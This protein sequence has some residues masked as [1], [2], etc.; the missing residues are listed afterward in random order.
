MAGAARCE[1]QLEKWYTMISRAGAISQPAERDARQVDAII[2]DLE[3][4]QLSTECAAAV[5]MAGPSRVPP[6]TA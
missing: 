2:G 4:R 3:R 1:L 5:G 6:D